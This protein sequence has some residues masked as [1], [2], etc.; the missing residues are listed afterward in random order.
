[1]SVKDFMMLCLPY[2]GL[3]N[4]DLDVME[5]NYTPRQRLLAAINT[6]Y[7][8]ISISTDTYQK[9]VDVL[10]EK[11]GRIFEYK[12]LPRVYKVLSVKSNG[13]NIKFHTIVNGIELEEKVEGYVTVCYSFFPEALIEGNILVSGINRYSFLY[14][15]L[16]EYCLMIGLFDKSEMFFQ[17]HLLSSTIDKRIKERRVESSR[18]I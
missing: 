17:K 14:R 5:G 7:G 18:W 8:E 16:S 15:V 11:D 1:M 4:A 9:I 2:L 12:G 3:T 6:V 13:K 10:P